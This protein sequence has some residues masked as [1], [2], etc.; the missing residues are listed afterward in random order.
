MRLRAEKVC[1]KLAL[2]LTLLS[3][4]SPWKRQTNEIRNRIARWCDGGGHSSS[5]ST[6]PPTTTIPPAFKTLLMTSAGASAS[7]LL[8]PGGVLSLHIKILLADDT[9][10]SNVLSNGRWQLQRKASNTSSAG[11]C[12]CDALFSWA[13]SSKKNVFLLELYCNSEKS[14]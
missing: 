8:G 10:Q 13:Q 7:I 5:L 12:S 14:M 9:R 4:P 11:P 2:N 1:L 3:K 6:Y